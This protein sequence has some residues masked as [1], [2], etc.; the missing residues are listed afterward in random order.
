MAG[1]EF[2]GVGLGPTWTGQSPVP[3]QLDVAAGELGPL[4]AGVCPIGSEIP[5]CISAAGCVSCGSAFGMSGAGAGDAISGVL[6]SA[7]SGFGSQAESGWVGVAL[8]DEEDEVG[9]VPG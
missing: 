9:Q 4:A 7:E 6:T 1:I 5:A 3:A 8:S 2:V